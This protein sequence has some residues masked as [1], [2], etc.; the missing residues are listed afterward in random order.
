LKHRVK[1]RFH[2]GTHFTSASIFLLDREE[3]LPGEAGFVQLRLDR[4]VVALP[5]DRFVILGTSEIQTIGGGRV[6]DTRP[7]K[8][9]RYSPS[10]IKD[11]TVLAEGSGKE[12]MG[13]HIFRS[14]AG[15]SSLVSS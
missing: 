4:P 13:Q 7:T 2:I 14:G 6:L 12:I 1:H 3:L 9:K 5:E 10:M 15:G 8:H 11:L